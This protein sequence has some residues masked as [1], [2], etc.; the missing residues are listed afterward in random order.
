MA[1]RTLAEVYG[2]SSPKRRAKKLS[3]RNLRSVILQEVRAVLNE[4]GESAGPVNVEG[5]PEKYQNP[6]GTAM[7]GKDN[8]ASKDATEIVA[9]LVSGDVKMPIFAAIGE[10]HN[11]Q[12]TPG[13]PKASTAEGAAAIADWAKKA[14]PDFLQQNITNI[15]GKLPSGGKSKSEM[16]ALEPMDVGHVKD[17]LSPGGQIN[18]DMDDPSADDIAD[19]E[20]WHQDHGK[21]AKLGGTKKESRYSLAARLLEDK[22]PQ[23]HKGGMSGAPVKGEKDAVDLN[24]IKDLALSFLTKGLQSYDDDG[25]DDMIQVKEN[26]PI[27][28]ASMIPTQQNVLLGKSLAF[29]IGGGFGGQELG[30]YIT[31]GNEILDGHHRWAGTMIVDPGAEIKGHKVMAPAAEILPV[32]TTL[33]NALGR[34]QKGME[35]NESLSPSD[36]VLLERWRKLAGLL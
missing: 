9:Q 20:Q 35:H 34:Q 21:E 15:Q 18:I 6:A 23:G 13:I 7:K 33:G 2:Y 8:I 19:V 5:V 36:N 1:K 32:L 30:A 14:G 28:V 24:A 10:Y 4:A 16:P 17:A 11:P 22:F 27:Q 12:F 3:S 31:G 25:A 26:E 29:A